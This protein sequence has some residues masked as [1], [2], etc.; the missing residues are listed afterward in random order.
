MRTVDLNGPT[1]MSWHVA[2]FSYAR[3]DVEAVH[4]WVG[5]LYLGVTRYRHEA[6]DPDLCAIGVVYNHVS[7][8]HSSPVSN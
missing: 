7:L 3:P 5:G 4:P 1:C 6:D 8:S 2:C